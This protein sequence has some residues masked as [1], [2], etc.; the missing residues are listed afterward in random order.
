MTLEID[1]RQRDEPGREH[2]ERGQDPG[3]VVSNRQPDEER[4][5]DGGE[6]NRATWV[7]VAAAPS[8]ERLA[9]RQPVDDDLDAQP[10]EEAGPG[11]HRHDRR[12]HASAE[13]AARIIAG[14]P[15]PRPA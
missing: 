1:D 7:D 4:D 15:T 8:V 5:G 9:L 6:E 3:V 14:R 11:A 13:A 10:D 2:Q 12:S